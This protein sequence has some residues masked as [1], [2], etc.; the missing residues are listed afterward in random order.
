MPIKRTRG[1]ITKII[2]KNLLIGGTILISCTSPYFVRSVLSAILK[3]KK[4]FGKNFSKTRNGFYYLR[5][6]GLI[7][8]EI[9]NRQIYISLTPEGKK[10]AGKYQIDDLYIK[11]PRRWDQKWR[12]VIFD[13]ANKKKIVREALRGKL[14]ELGFYK[15]QKSVWIYPY[16][17]KKEIQLLKDFFNLK[18]KEITLI[19][20]EK[21]ENET[22][23]KKKFKLA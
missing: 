17:C 5:R 9:K 11:K 21:I 16:N 20:A 23:Y 15:I 10:Q 7:K 13:I 6:C 18:T 14:K 4:Y 2:L 1:E 22:F 19:T 12:L 3:N 8:T